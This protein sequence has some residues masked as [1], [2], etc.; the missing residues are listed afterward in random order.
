MLTE[1]QKQAILDEAAKFA[2]QRVQPIILDEAAKGN[3]KIVPVIQPPTEEDW[4]EAILQESAQEHDTYRPK[5]Y[6]KT[7]RPKN[8]LR[9][10]RTAK[11]ISAKSKARNKPKGLSRR[12]KAKAL[13]K[14]KKR[15]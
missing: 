5:G 14:R 9:K 4:R 3:T 10:R 7:T 13:H 15:S 6:G 8:L 12:K 1:E 2:A 11:K